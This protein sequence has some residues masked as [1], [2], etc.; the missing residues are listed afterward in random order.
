MPRR[1]DP[2]AKPE[3]KAPEGADD[4]NVLAPDV[5]LEVAGRKL[6]VREYTF[7]SGMRVR[8]KAKAL[9]D[10]LETFVKD[11]AAVD[12]GEED[13]VD[14]LAKHFE[15]V[16]ELMLDSIEGADADYLDA[17]SEADG[18]TLLLTWWNVCG[19]FFVRV[20]GARLHD[21]LVAQFRRRASA[22]PTSSAPSASPDTAPLATLAPGTPSVN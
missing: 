13:H 5:E 16:R 4:L 3:P 15:L 2:N 10:D 19:R 20:V 7:L 17:L 9:I 14:L 8:R 18:K 22:G 6:T 1:I 12:A 11:G 21:R